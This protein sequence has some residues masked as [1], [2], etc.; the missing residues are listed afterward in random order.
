MRIVITGAS[1]EL[2]RMSAQA[3]LRTLDPAQLILVSRNPDKL[4]DFAR[5]GVEI[6][7]AD[8]DEPASLAPAFAGA[9]RL[10]LISTADVGERRRAQHDAAIRAA[11]AT[12]G[13][14]HIAYTS[15]TGIHPRN[16]SFVIPD[17]RFTEER[18]RASPLATTILRMNS[19]ADILAAMVAPQAI[20]SG[21]WI[22]RG[23]DGAIGWVAKADCAAAAAGVLTGDGHEGAVYEI[24]GPELL[25]NREAAALAAELS[26]RS[27]DY[28]VPD[29]T[30]AADTAED[31]QAAK[32]IGAFTME[33]LY[34][35]E[36]AVRDGHHAIC[37]HHVEMITG[38]PALSL[39]ALFLANLDRLQT[40]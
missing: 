17:H 35:F 37:T 40:A 13:M 16:P 21:Q 2:G 7:H 3:A 18:L 30:L 23:G 24:T 26:G 11:E 8:F 29:K 14:R 19:Y 31:D 12:P 4:A 25:S 36:Y 22:S 28:V 20:A 34:S 1:G 27:I 15:S 32:W 39:R 38:R 5:R 9:G 6:R 10:L 33:D